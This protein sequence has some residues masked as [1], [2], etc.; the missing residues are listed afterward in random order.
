LSI[1]LVG[2]IPVL[3][4]A[5]CN[6]NKYRKSIVTYE[7]SDTLATQ[8]DDTRCTYYVSLDPPGVRCRIRLN[9]I[10]YRPNASAYHG[11]SAFPALV[12]NHGSGEDIPA[13]EFCE[14][15]TYYVPKGYIVFVPFRR[16]HGEGG[17]RSTG[18]F[19]TDLI[20]DYTSGAD[21]Y[22]H[23]T[24]CA[25]SNN[26][27]YRAQ[28]LDEQASE[29]IRDAMDYMKERADVLRDPV[30]QADPNPEHRIA[31]MGSSYGGAVTVFANSRA[32]GQKVAVAFSA[33]AQQWN[34]DEN[35]APFD[36]TC[37]TATQR[38]L[39]NAAGDATK[40]AYYLQ[41]RWDYDTRSTIDLAYAHS[42]RSPRPLHSRAWMAQIF[43]Y[44]YPCATSDPDSCTDDDYQ[45]IHRGFVRDPKVW[46]PSVTN[47]LR[48]FDVT[49]D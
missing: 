4:A 1:A 5:E 24:S 36:P 30:T 19:I 33:G 6:S 12:I 15:A 42:Y 29:E 44:Q 37:G 11:N 20:D 23:N 41:A 40:P 9:G 49:L 7:Q 3:A 26:S 18:I 47:F 48:R 10:L 28:L 17:D 16:G 43:P 14:I 38:A 2:S 34:G 21:S 31:I 35:C 32:L 46:G 45:E 25:R 8:F 22:I 27:C 13:N 39:I